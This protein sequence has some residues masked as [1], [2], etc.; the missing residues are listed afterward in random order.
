[1]ES[2]PW[3]TSLAFLSPPWC[4]SR[5]SGFVICF[6]SGCFV[7]ARSCSHYGSSYIHPHFDRR[8]RRRTLSWTSSGCL[9]RNPLQPHHDRA[10]RVDRGNAQLLEKQTL[11]RIR[12][13]PERTFT[14]CRSLYRP[15]R[16]ERH[17][18]SSPE[19]RSDDRPGWRGL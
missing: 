3:E 4:S 1:M 17:F 13:R 7:R 10:D 5:I 9:S 12:G 18:S 14:S 8:A 11:S 15:R 2:Q 6:I 19:K 16:G